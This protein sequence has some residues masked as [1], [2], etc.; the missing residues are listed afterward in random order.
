[1]LERGSIELK[2]RPQL[3]GILEN[4]IGVKNRDSKSY[5]CLWTTL[6]SAYVCSVAFH[7]CSCF[8]VV[9]LNHPI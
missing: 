7:F 1:M 2:T 6:V 4:E 9:A 5:P 3:C 8:K